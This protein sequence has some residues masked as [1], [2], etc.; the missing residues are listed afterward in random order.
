MHQKTA[1][2]SF[3]F[4][5]PATGWQALLDELPPDRRRALAAVHGGL[6]CDGEGETHNTPFLKFLSGQ[7]VSL[8]DEIPTNLTSLILSSYYVC[9]EPVLAHPRFQTNKNSRNTQKTAGCCL[10]RLCPL[11]AELHEGL[12]AVRETPLY[13]KNDHFAKTGSGQNVGKWC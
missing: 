13:T 8:L 4:W 3:L 7:S 10:H 1:S 11:A 2:F 6:P 12:Y 5:F 9:P